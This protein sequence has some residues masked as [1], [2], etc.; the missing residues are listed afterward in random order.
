MINKKLIRKI[1]KYII[2]FILIK[3]KITIFMIIE[4]LKY[5]HKYLN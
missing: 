4:F 1:Y 3:P 5:L 2:D